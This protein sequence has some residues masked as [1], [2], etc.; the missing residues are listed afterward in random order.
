MT[1]HYALIRRYNL[2]FLHFLTFPRVVESEALLGRSGVCINASF[3][4]EVGA[5]IKLQ[6]EE[7]I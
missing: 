4:E 2:G 3:Y 7:G 6:N 1:V 5:Q